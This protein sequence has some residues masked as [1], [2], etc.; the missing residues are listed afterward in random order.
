MKRLIILYIGLLLFVFLSSTIAC[1]PQSDEAQIESLI[2]RA[3]VATARTDWHAVYNMTT[4]EF[5][6]SMTFKEYESYINSHMNWLVQD[7][8]QT[9]SRCRKLEASNVMVDI[10]GVNADAS[11][12]IT[13]DGMTLEDNYE[14]FRKVGGR[15][16]I[17]WE[18]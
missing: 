15:W 17:E 10:D 8:I 1:G 14:T 18:P 3:L 13:C 9:I 2:N 4:P 11:Y 16:F 12:D 7:Y 6:Q 5:R